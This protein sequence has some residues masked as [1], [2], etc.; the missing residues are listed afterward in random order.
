MAGKSGITNNPD[1]RKTPRGGGRRGVLPGITCALALAVLLLVALVA[2]A[3]ATPGVSTPGATAAGALAPALTFPDVPANHPYWTAIDGLSDLGIIGGYTN[4]YFGRDDPVKRAQFSKMIVG[5][6]GIIPN[7]STFTRFTDL[8]F[9]DANGYPHRWVQ[10]AY[11]NGI[12]YGTNQAQ[13]LF[14]P[15][16]NIRRDQAISMMVRGASNLYPGSLL[17]PPPGTPSWFAGVPEPHGSNLRIAEY[18]GLL[19]G[20]IGFGPSWNYSANATRGEVAQMFYDLLALIGAPSG[21]IWVFVDG[22][23]TYPTIES[24]VANIA[25]GETIYLG[26]GTFY[27]DDTII[28]DFPFGLVGSGMS[29]PNMTT[30]R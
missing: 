15:Y 22:S 16:N 28:V 29:G 20:L 6:L 1:P 9:P 27:L 21:E 12:T 26:P 19:D 17:M 11:D 25:P 3:A 2:P 8:G 18:N 24:A 14:A 23:G 4:G 10:T 13:T 30:V 7:A 5:T